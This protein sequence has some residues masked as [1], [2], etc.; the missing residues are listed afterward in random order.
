[1]YKLTEA[2]KNRT[3]IVAIRATDTRLGADVAWN[4]AIMAA[5]KRKSYIPLPLAAQIFQVTVMTV[6]RWIA[7]DRVNASRNGLTFKQLNRIG[8]RAPGS[9]AR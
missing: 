5:R 9:L 1:M 7:A 6:R 3:G 8:R 2:R 4:D